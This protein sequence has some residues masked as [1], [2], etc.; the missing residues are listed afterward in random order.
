MK[1]QSYSD[2]AQQKQILRTIIFEVF[3]FSSLRLH[4]LL[5]FTTIIWWAIIAILIIV[6]IWDIS[7]QGKRPRVR[8]FRTPLRDYMHGEFDEQMEFDL[9]LTHKRFKQLFPF[10]SITYPEYK[11][12]HMER[13][14]RRAVGS[15]KNKRMVR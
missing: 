10:L 7:E 3:V 1:S 15:K 6:V 14:F 4:Y 13:T 2:G 11:K 5:P 8:R 9:R 12:L